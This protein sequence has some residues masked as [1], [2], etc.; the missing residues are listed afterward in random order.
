M[1]SPIVHAVEGGAVALVIHSLLEPQG[2]GAM[3]PIAIPLVAYAIHYL[4]DRIKH[5]DIIHLLTRKLFLIARTVDPKDEIH[6]LPIFYFLPGGREKLR[7]IE[8][9]LADPEPLDIPE[10]AKGWVLADVGLAGLVSFVLILSHYQNPWLAF[11]VGLGSF[12]CI[13]PDGLLARPV[14]QRFMKHNWFWWQD[15]MHHR[16]HAKIIE[17]KNRWWGALSQIVMFLVF[18]FLFLLVSPIY[19]P[20]ISGAIMP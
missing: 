16:C 17:Y 5:I 20:L 12:F 2:W 19:G 9:L 14:Q 4:T 6:K 7:V 18:A 11:Y 1:A 3:A 15:I 8:P 10:E 13:L